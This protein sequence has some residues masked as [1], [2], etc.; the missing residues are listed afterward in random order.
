MY[1]VTPT[2]LFIWTVSPEGAVRAETVAVRETRLADLVR[3]TAP[4]GGG[5]SVPIVAALGPGAQLHWSWQRPTRRPGA[6]C[7]AYCGPVR[8]SLPRT[9]GALVTIVPHGPLSMLSFAALQDERDRY[10]IEDFT[11]NYVPAG[12]VLGFRRRAAPTPRFERCA[13]RRGSELPPQVDARCIA[14]GAAGLPARSALHRQ[15]VGEGS[16]HVLEG[17]AAT[18]RRVR[19]LTAGKGA[20]HFATHAIVSNADPFNSFL[21]L[22]GSDHVPPTMER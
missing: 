13:R 19:D 7:T 16:R 4:L 12:A 9:R 2:R 18:E 20:L 21:A 15:V 1:W 11:L 17:D 10:L 14:A 22:A 3:S 6:S 5:V 8:D